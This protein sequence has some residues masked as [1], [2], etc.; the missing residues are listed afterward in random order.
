MT[1]PLIANKKRESEAAAFHR[2]CFKAHGR[3]CFFCGKDASD[4][5]HV[6]PRS[7]LGP[8]RY[9]IPVQNSRPGCRACHERQ[10]A[11]ELHFPVRVVRIAIAAHN[12]LS[13]VKMVMP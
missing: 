1:R 2:S 6:I 8:L 10:E 11:G 9:A 7:H 4:A 5:M 12:K 13:K 3:A